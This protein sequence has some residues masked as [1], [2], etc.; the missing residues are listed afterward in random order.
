MT[1]RLK[2]LLITLHILIVLLIGLLAWQYFATKPSK[3]SVTTPTTTPVATTKDTD[4]STA[5]KKGTNDD[6]TAVTEEKSSV[7]GWKIFKNLTQKYL[8]EYPSDATVTNGSATAGEKDKAAENANCVR[9]STSNIDVIIAGRSIDKG[10]DCLR[11]GVGTQ[12][13]EAP[14]ETVTIA[15][16]E[17]TVKGMKSESASAG[18]YNDDYIVTL[19]SGEKIE[20]GISVNEKMD[21]TATKAQAKALVHKILGTFSPAE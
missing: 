2:W 17:Y 19:A 3:K 9:I 15:G 11:T 10:V 20:Y 8:I 1:K 18:Y 6:T 5:T 7:D 16:I 4:A 13:S 21:E 14:E 12:W